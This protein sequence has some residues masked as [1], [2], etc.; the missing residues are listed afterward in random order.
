[1]RQST[2]SEG[3]LFSLANDHK[4]NIHL[5]TVLTTKSAEKKSFFSIMAVTHS[6]DDIM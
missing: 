6:G 3:A 5:L 2:S 1:M 4:V